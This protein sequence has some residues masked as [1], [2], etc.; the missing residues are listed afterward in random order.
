MPMTTGKR[1]W[2]GIIAGVA[3]AGA[4]VLIGG[5]MAAGERPAELASFATSLRG[6]T[7]A[8]IHN[9]RLALAAI[10]GAVIRPGA[11]FSFN[12]TVGSWS[13]DRG[14]KQA[15]VSYDGE[16]VRSWGGG[17]CQTSTTLYNAALLAGLEVVERHRHHWAPHYVAPGRD[18]AVAFSNI[19]LKLE[20]NREAPVQIAGRIEGD[21]LKVAI[22]GEREGGPRSSVWTEVRD[23]VPR[24]TVTLSDP[25]LPVGVRRTV[26]PGGPGFLVATYRETRYPGGQTRRVL[27]SEDRYPRMN[28]VVRVGAG[29]ERGSA[30]RP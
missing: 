1:R 30:A 23:V 26:N 24:Q 11:T 10:D 12:E 29:G 8:Q 3:A 5:L 7:P 9:A 19:D 4:V 6:R 13:A 16:L 14:Y 17:V 15:L 21:S 2:T 27:V 28:R 22:L 20:S 18:A 25:A